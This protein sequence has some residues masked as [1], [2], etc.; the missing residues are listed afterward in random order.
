MGDWVVD[1]CGWVGTWLLLVCENKVGASQTGKL[2]TMKCWQTTLDRSVPATCA[3]KTQSR[4]AEITVLRMLTSRCCRKTLVLC[5]T[6]GP[7]HMLDSRWAE[8]IPQ[9][10]P[11]NTFLPAP[12]LGVP[13]MKCFWEWLNHSKE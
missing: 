6:Q 13:A 10:Q 3:S 1:G 2:S 9:G 7:G 5:P 8:P 11:L 4:G 12:S